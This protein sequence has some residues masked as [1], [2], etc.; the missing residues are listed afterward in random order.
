[1]RGHPALFTENG[2]LGHV[3]NVPKLADMVESGRQILR[4]LVVDL[5]RD[6]RQL[7][8]INRA[9]VRRTHGGAGSS[10]ARTRRQLLTP[11]KVRLPKPTPLRDIRR[12][13][14]FDVARGSMR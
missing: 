1:M 14:A 7:P 3:E 6:D 2:S 12:T 10:N 4:R 5:E 13:R 11:G 8:T 9:S